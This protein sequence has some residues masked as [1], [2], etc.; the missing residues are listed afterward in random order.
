MRTSA[1]RTPGGFVA[2]AAA[3]T[4]RARFGFG[5]KDGFGVGLIAA[6][7]GAAAAMAA[8]VAVAVWDDSVVT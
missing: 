6:A 4:V 5:G 1:A 3:G 2:G 8:V 7:D